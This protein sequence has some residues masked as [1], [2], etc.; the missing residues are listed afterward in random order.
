MKLV[1]AQHAVTS[2]GPGSVE[3]TNVSNDVLSQAQALQIAAKA[4][5]EGK[6]LFFTRGELGNE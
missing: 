4:I 1:D 2:Y 5:F 3:I 6:S